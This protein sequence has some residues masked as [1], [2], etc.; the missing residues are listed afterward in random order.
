MDVKKTLISFVERP[1]LTERNH[2][3]TKCLNMFIICVYGV[4]QKVKERKHRDKQR[5]ETR[6]VCI[7]VWLD[8]CAC[9]YTY[10]TCCSYRNVFLFLFVVFHMSGIAIRIDDTSVRTLEFV[11][12]VGV[13]HLS[14]DHLRFSKA[15]S[16]RSLCLSLSHFFSFVK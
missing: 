3:C 12:L 2:F 6:C 9:E 7:F 10:R 4:G 8:A 15:V 16:V 1:N 5:Q 14:A 11:V 13:D